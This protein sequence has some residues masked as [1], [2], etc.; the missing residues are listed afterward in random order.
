MGV[1]AEVGVEC[2]PTDGQPL[3]RLQPVDTSG[4]NRAVR[5]PANEARGAVSICQIAKAGKM[6]GQSAATLTFHQARNS[7]VELRADDNA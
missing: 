6:Y 3:A 1:A 5:Q 4:L 7:A 2:L